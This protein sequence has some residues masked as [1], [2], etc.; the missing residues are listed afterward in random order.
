MVEDVMF[1]LICSFPLSFFATEMIVVTESMSWKLVATQY[2]LNEAAIGVAIFQK[3]KDN[4]EL[5]E[6]SCRVCHKQPPIL[7]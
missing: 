6:I 5:Y 2:N 4:H 1:D 7:F 3:P